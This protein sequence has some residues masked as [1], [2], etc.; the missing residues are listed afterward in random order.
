MVKSFLSVAMVLTTSQLVFA[1][2]FCPQDVSEKVP[3]SRKIPGS[4]ERACAEAAH[5]IAEGWIGGVVFA[6]VGGKPVAMG[7]AMPGRPMTETT[8]FDIASVTKVIT[9]CA[10]A[11]LVAEGK[12]DEGKLHALATHTVTGKFEYDCSNFVALGQEIER[13]S[14]MRLDEFC[15][16]RIF[17]PLGMKRTGWWPVTDDG[18][19]CRMLPEGT[20]LGT[21]SDLRARTAGVPLGNAGVFSDAPDMLR[22][23]GDLLYRRTFP[24]K[25]Y[26]LL[27]TCRYEEAGGIRRSFGFDMSDALRPAGLSTSTIYHNGWTGQTLAVDP[28]TGFAGVVLT[29]RT[30][31]YG[32][33]KESRRRMLSAMAAEIPKRK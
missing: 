32:A 21:V 9:A 3:G 26:D 8:R 7:E 2:P 13:A 14:D 18:T 27:F 29:T 31:D 1:E 28:E 20:P 30:G 12:L 11:L 15:R 6:C 23:A 17:E 25:C 4:S 24:K 10:A 19:L 16:K 22:F 5:A 33:A